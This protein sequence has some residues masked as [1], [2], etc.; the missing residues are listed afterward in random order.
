[1]LAQALIGAA[2]KNST[3]GV[4][5]AWDPGNPHAVVSEAMIIL[6]SVPRLNQVS[7]T[8]SINTPLSCTKLNKISFN[9]LWIGLVIITRKSAVLEEG[10]NHGASHPIMSDTA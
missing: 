10:P 1:M 8:H 5:P 4:K 2:A 3:Q 6:L 7:M 9:V